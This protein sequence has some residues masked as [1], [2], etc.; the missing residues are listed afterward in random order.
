MNIKSMT[1]NKDYASWTI[2]FEHDG[3][4]YT[5]VVRINNEMLENVSATDIP[6]FALDLI[7][8]ELADSNEISKG[9]LDE[10]YCEIT[11]TVW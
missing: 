7:R 10:S 11:P 2:V 4:E 5:V 1:R 9:F 6:E 3:K 8:D